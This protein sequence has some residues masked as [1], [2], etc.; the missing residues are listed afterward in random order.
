L[1]RF[2]T[3]ALGAALFLTS[4]APAATQAAATASPSP[5]PAVTA[6][7]K[8]FYH[9]LVT[10][11]ID[12]S[13]LSGQANAK[14]TDQ[15]VKDVAAKLAPL[16]DPITFEFVKSEQQ[17]GSMLHAYL[18]GFGNGQKLEFVVGFDAQGKVSALAL[19]PAP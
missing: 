10:G 12:R 14:L 13:Q 4:V 19:Q 1:H 3:L 7:V 8:T 11:T 15:T 16:G 17:G 9:A 5:D 2:T 6:R 18:L